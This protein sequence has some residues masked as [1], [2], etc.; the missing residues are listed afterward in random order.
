[1]ESMLELVLLVIIYRHF[2][3]TQPCSTVQFL[4]ASGMQKQREKVWESDVDVYL[5]RQRWKGPSTKKKQC[6]GLF[7]QCRSKSE[8]WTFVK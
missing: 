3:Y 5:G 8:S 1:M 7:L 2:V 6:S 4:I